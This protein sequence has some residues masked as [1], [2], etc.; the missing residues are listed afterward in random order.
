GPLADAADHGDGLDDAGVVEAGE[1][2]RVE[3]LVVEGGGDRAQA[4]DLLAREAAGAQARRTGP[5]QH[6]RRRDAAAVGRAQPRLD[7]ARG[8][9]RDLL[10]ED[11]AHQVAV[12]VAAAAQ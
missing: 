1:A 7:R 9:A 12:R 3:Q 2:A 11:R 6:R 5:A 4:R 8:V 10:V